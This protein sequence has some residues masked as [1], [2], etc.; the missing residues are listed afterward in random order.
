MSSN[1]QNQI[2]ETM[3]KM[4]G[5]QIMRLVDKD[6]TIQ[7]YF[8][9]WAALGACAITLIIVIL[10]PFFPDGPEYTKG[11]APLWVTAFAAIIGVI[12]LLLSTGWTRVRFVPRLLV[13]TS[14]WSASILLTW[15]SA[16]IVFDALR[17]AAVLGI[18][19]L[20]PVV[21]WL[22][23]ASRA[24][25]LTG[26]ILLAM[27]TISYQRVS[28][29]ACVSCGQGLL[30][31][32]K[33]RSNAWLGYTAFILS[34]PYPL[35][36]IYWSIGGALGGG[37]NFGDHTAFGEIL[38]FGASALLSLALVQRWGRIFPRWV[39]FFA[40]KKVPR[41]ILITGGWIAACMTAP[42]GLLA[43]FGALM[44][45]LGLADGP[46]RFD[47]NGLMVSMVYGGWLLLGIALGGAT[48]GYQQQT[49]ASC[50]QCGQ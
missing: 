16:G 49:R 5:A 11:F 46:V 4:D 33:I 39:P 20:P 34:F 37:Q 31:K 8:K 38:V 40:G 6:P 22:G 18:P 27:V 12:A 42:M 36:K 47:G 7:S 26:A 30:I 17:T 9:V 25:S 41:W 23:F 48:W 1:N 21:D 3:T 29:G 24:I 50:V 10:K 35:L 45:A 19:G 43:I 14:A 44:Q 2:G 15:S 32:G 28:R 13:L